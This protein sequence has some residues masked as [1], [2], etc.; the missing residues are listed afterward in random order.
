MMNNF[1][2]V[3]DIIESADAIGIYMVEVIKTI[4]NHVMYK[5]IAIDTSCEFDSISGAI[6]PERLQVIIKA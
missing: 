3:G 1:L 6:N 4:Q 5:A 2:Q